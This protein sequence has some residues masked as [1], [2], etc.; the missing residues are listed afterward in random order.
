MKTHRFKTIS[1]AFFRT[2]KKKQYKIEPK[3]PKKGF[4]DLFTPNPPDFQFKGRVS[5]LAIR[6]VMNRYAKT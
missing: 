3:V 1:G 5:T 2:L 4:Q 6:K